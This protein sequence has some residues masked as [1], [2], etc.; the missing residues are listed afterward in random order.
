MK[1]KPLFSPIFAA[2]IL[3]SCNKEIEFKANNAALI[4]YKYESNWNLV[5]M[6]TL[7]MEK[8]IVQSVL[9]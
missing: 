7:W 8:N 1:Y 2:I 9:S 3:W 5:K 4:S 6:D